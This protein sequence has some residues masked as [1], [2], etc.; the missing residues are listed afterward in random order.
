MKSFIQQVVVGLREKDLSKHIF[1]L[2]SRRAANAFKKTLCQSQSKTFFLPQIESIEEFIERLSNSQIIDQLETVF[3]FYKVYKDITNPNH[4]ESFDNVYAWAETIVHDFNEIDRHRINAEQFFGNLKDIKDIE[5][6]S[7]SPIKTEI[8]ENYLDFWHQLPKYYDAL[9]SALSLQNK[10]YQGMAYDQAANRIETYLQQTEEDLIFIGFNALNTCEE[11]IFQTVLNSNR[12]EVFW[13]IDEHLLKNNQAGKFIR[14]YRKDWKHY[15]NQPLQASIKS[16]LDEKHIKNYGVAKKIGQAKLVGDLLSKLS[17]SEIQNTALVLG[18]EALLQP[19]LNALPE[20]ISKANVTM[21]LPLNQTTFATCFESM[22]KFKT[23]PEDKLYFKTILEIC[24]HP[25]FKQAYQTPFFEIKKHITEGNIIFQSK[26]EFFEYCQKFSSDFQELMQ[27]CFGSTPEKIEDFISNCLQLIEILKPSFEN[28]RLQLEYLFAFKQLFI[29][30]QNLILKNGFVD[31]YKAFYQ[32]YLDLLSSETLDF[33]GSP[34]DGLQIM[35]MLETRVLD[36]ENIIITSVNEGVLPSGKSQNS[37]IPYDLKMAFGLPTYKEKDNVY[38]YHFFRL[39][40]R[41]KHCYFIYNNE[42]SGIEKAEKS[43][44]LTQLEIFKAQSHKIENFTVVADVSQQ[45]TG[46]KSISKT[47][48][49]LQKLKELFQ[50]GISPSALTTYIRN[51]ID[52]YQKY[53]LGIRE[54]DD[55]EEEVSYKTHGNVVHDTLENLYSEFVDKNLTLENLDELLKKYPAEIT[56]QFEIHFNSE[57]IKFGRN[58]INFEIAK[59]QTKRFLLQ[60]KESLRHHKLKILHLETSRKITMEI[61]DLDFKVALKG[62]VDRIDRL[63]GQLRIIDYKTGKVE[64]KDLRIKEDWTDFTSD[65]KYG[66]AFQVLFYA[67]LFESELDAESLAG[68]ISFKNL[69]QGFLSF[70]QGKNKFISK[71]VLEA[72]SLQLESL[73]LEIMNPEIPFQEKQV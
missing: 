7:K 69:N 52:F 45:K 71:D 37:F 32:I 16:F 2:P 24:G 30:I 26:T 53:V 8:V 35:G 27:I 12:G 51:P 55:V 17:D 21:G 64:A 22:I 13:D 38:A 5:H 28:N 72:F 58:L 6:W 23:Q 50:Y 68:I 14:N 33:Q 62:K 40:Q 25:M 1:V 63:D 9:K 73:I 19:I 4:Q 49:M 36:Y 57:A 11:L 65:Y 46:L 67:K 70:A 61:P 15:Q 54:I 29:K 39:M 47:P 59:Q 42:T 48:E 10:A 18:D 3:E 60:E 34:Y 31:N 41:A 20:N 43:R 44:F 66:K 56:R